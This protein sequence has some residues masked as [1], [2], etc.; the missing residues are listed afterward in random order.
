MEDR[1]QKY[2]EIS[3]I[4]DMWD[5]NRKE[6]PELTKHEFINK[7]LDNK[8]AE[9][10]CYRGLIEYE[11]ECA[12]KNQRVLRAIKSVK[13]IAFYKH[14]LA[15]IKESEGIRDVAEIVREPI[16]TFQKEQYGRSI[17]GIWVNQTTDGGYL[18][19]SYAGTI[20]I[21]L[22]PGRY[23]KFHYAM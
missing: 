13:G 11:N 12:R 15:I 7:Y 20:C 3:G 1:Q 21:E 22:K 10:D 8:Q 17:K 18:G 5:W 16:G 9:E 23:L 4:L 2:W 14:I 19:D 6:K